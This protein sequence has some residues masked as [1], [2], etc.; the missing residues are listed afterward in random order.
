MDAGQ[1]RE[2]IGFYSQAEAA[3]DYGIAADPWQL[4]FVRAARARAIRTGEQIMAQRLKGVKVVIITVRYNAAARTINE[5]WQAR[6]MRTNEA[7]NIRKAVPDERREWIDVLAESG[8]A[9]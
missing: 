6:D 4:Q 8:V 9:Q 3:T 2:K 5:G 1:L 7:Y